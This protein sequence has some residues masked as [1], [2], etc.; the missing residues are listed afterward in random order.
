MEFTDNDKLAGLAIIAVLAY[1]FKPCKCKCQDIAHEELGD[2]IVKEYDTNGARVKNIEGIPDF[3]F[4][5][6]LVP[7]NDTTSP[8]DKIMQ[9]GKHGALNNGT[10]TITAPQSVYGDIVSIYI[11]N[12]IIDDIDERSIYGNAN[13]KYDITGVTFNSTDKVVIYFGNN[14]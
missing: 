6:K 4:N 8:P 14:S 7:Y 11:N 3:V 10:I 12:Q 13:G 5:S 2:I 1:V 9:I